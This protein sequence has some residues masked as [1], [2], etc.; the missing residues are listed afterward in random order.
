MPTTIN[1]H[2]RMERERRTVEAMIEIYCHQIHGTG[3]S[4]CPSCEALADYARQ[5]LRK[6]PFQ[7]GKTTCA[8]CPVH[9]YKPDARQEIRA[10][11]RY[12]G[13]RML[14]RHP[15]M[16]LWHL[17]DGRRQEPVRLEKAGGSSARVTAKASGRRSQ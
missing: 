6:C 10:V 13:P 8:K 3:N 5:R 12:A 7:E 17:I 1:T 4:L 16:A 11:M 14:H 9:C 15:R 2:P